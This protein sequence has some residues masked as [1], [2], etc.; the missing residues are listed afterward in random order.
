MEV[1]CLVFLKTRKGKQN[2]RSYKTQKPLKKGFCFVSKFVSRILFSKE[3]L[4]FIYIYCCQQTLAAYPPTI[5]R[6]A[7][8]RWFT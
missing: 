8:K 6:A 2:T 1:T 7:L 3:P 5:V 4:S